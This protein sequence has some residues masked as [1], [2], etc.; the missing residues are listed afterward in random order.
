MKKNTHS[1]VLKIKECPRDDIIAF[2]YLDIL[3][4]KGS[5][6]SLGG[7][8][9]QNI[10]QLPNILLCCFTFTCLMIWRDSGHGVQ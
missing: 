2:P 8:V 6:P 3:G 4:Y 1:Q 5:H 10:L 7:R 9:S